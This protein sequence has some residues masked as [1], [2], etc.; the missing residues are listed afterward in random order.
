MNY[1]KVLKFEV[2]CRPFADR[3]CQAGGYSFDAEQILQNM[4][5]KMF[6]LQKNVVLSPNEPRHHPKSLYI[7]HFSESLSP[8]LESPKKG[9][10][11]FS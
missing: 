1:F 5:H 10:K 11:S 8:W 9:A 2:L 6:L 7:N 4:E 3:I